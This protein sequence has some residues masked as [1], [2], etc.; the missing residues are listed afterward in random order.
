MKAQL[1]RLFFT[2]RCT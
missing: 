1:S 2:V